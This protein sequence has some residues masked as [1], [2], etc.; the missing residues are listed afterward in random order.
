MP[1]LVAAHQGAAGIEEMDAVAPVLGADPFIHLDAVGADGDVLGPFNPDATP[2]PLQIVVLNDGS[3]CISLDHNPGIH[4]RE[5]PPPV[6]ETAI[7]NP[8]IPPLQAQHIP[9]S[10]CIQNRTRRA[11]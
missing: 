10:L 7:L 8:D 11:A 4:R 9:H 2:Y 3:A 1:D 5:V 6:A